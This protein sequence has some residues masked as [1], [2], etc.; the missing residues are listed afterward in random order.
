M[1]PSLIK[2]LLCASALVTA[3]AGAMAQTKWDMP[4]PYPETNFHTKNIKTFVDEVNANSG[5][6]LTITVHSNG[7][8]I[9]H[10]DIKRAVQTGQ[11]AIGEVLI[12]VQADRKSTRL[13]SSHRH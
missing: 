1:K 5:G 11:V 2:S 4:T 8:L 10:P 9:K 13:N 3:T 6:K 12:S 7:S